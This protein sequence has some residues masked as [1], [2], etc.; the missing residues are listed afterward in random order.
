MPC[1][2]FIA[3]LPIR[4]ALR[5]PLAP[6]RAPDDS[7]RRPASLVKA[8]SSLWPTTLIA[9]CTSVVQGFQR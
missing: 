9:H 7:A 8:G 3:L 2:E 4:P 1:R 5:E 6:T